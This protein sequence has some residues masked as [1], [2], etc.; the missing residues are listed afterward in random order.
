MRPAESICQENLN[1]GEKPQGRR[2]LGS[3]GRG[4][5]R[6]ELTVRHPW[7]GLHP[8]TLTGKVV[9]GPAGALASPRDGGAGLL[10]DHLQLRIVLVLP[11]RAV[12]QR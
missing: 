8:L 12:H 1:R 7:T 10:D 5:P 3:L 2:C 9:W 11:R 6:P 4:P